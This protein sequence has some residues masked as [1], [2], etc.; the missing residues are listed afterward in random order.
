MLFLYTF[1]NMRKFFGKSAC[2]FIEIF[3]C[4][5]M[6][7]HVIPF[8]VLPFCMFSYMAE[9]AY[10]Q[11][12][13]GEKTKII[14]FGSLPAIPGSDKRFPLTWIVLEKE[15][16]GSMLLLSRECIDYRRYHYRFSEIDWK[17]SDIRS[18]LNGTFYDMMFSSRD[19]KRIRN[20][21]VVNGPNEDYK[22]E[23]GDET[24]DNVFLLSMAEYKKYRSKIPVNTFNST[25][26]AMRKNNM[27]MRGYASWWLRT[28]GKNP[29]FVLYV[30][31]MN[32]S[33]LK[34]GV[35]STNYNHVRPALWLLPPV[36][37]GRSKGGKAKGGDSSLKPFALVPAAKGTAD[38]NIIVPDEPTTGTGASVSTNSVNYFLKSGQTPPQDT[39]AVQNTAEDAVP[40]TESP[41]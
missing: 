10:G 19:K 18:Y 38:G 13:D 34:M 4:R 20:T 36:K 11:I 14:N 25:Y 32:G 5:C 15:A 39:E 3:L 27:L 35:P 41:E 7:K 30:S 2:R 8:F 21:R 33:V 9:N 6:I 17:H 22:T 29:N 40:A 16:D 24:Y 26:S 12:Y 28:P 1:L 23:G 31:G 37:S